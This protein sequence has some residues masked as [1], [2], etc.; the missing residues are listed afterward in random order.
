MKRISFLTADV[1]SLLRPLLAYRSVEE[2]FRRNAT[3][4]RGANAILSGKTRLTELSRADMVLTAAGRPDLIQ[5][6]KEVRP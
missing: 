3:A 6:L 5:C 2:V 1:A 4:I